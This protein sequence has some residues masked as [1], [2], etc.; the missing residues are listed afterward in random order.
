[1]VNLMVK[2]IQKKAMKMSIPM[3]Q[4]PTNSKTTIVLVK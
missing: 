1:M 4:V 2:V 3:Y